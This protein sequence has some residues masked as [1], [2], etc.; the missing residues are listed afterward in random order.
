MFPINA[1]KACTESGSTAP[2][3]PNLGTVWRYVANYAFRS[4]YRPCG[5]LRYPLNRRLAGDPEAVWA[6]GRR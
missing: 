1:I 3:S 2:F 4:L 5:E 6:F